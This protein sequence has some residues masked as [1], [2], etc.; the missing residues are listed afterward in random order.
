MSSLLVTGGAGFIGSNLIR[1]LLAHDSQVRVVNLDL[2]TYAGNLESLEDVT[3]CYGPAGEAR[4]W[5][6]HGDI[7]DFDTVAAVLA[8]SEQETPAPGAKARE[9]PQPDAV[10]HLAGLSNDPLGALA[11]HLTEE[12]NYEGT[13]KLA[14]LAKQAGVSR[15]IYASSQSMYG[16]SNTQQ[17]LDEDDSDKNAITAYAITKWKAELALKE[18]GDGKFAV[19]YT[20]G[21]NTGMEYHVRWYNADGSAGATFFTT[22]PGSSTGADGWVNTDSLN[23]RQSVRMDAAGNFT[24]LHR[25]DA[26][27]SD[28][29]SP[30]SGLIE[31][32]DGFLYGTAS[33]GGQPVT[34][35][36]ETFAAR[37]L[38]AGDALGRHVL[39]EEII[40][41]KRELG[42]EIPW[43]VVGVVAD[44]KVG[45]LD[46]TSAGIYVSYA[47]SPIVGVSLLARGAVGIC[48]AKLTEAEAM[49]EHGV[50]TARYLSEAARLLL[51]RPRPPEGVFCVT[52]LLACGLIDGARTLGID[53]PRELCVIGF[54]DIPQAAWPAYGLTTF[55][56]DDVGPHRV[57][58]G[59]KAGVR[60]TRWQQASEAVD[61]LQDAPGGVLPAAGSDEQFEYGLRLMVTT[62][63][64]GNSPDPSRVFSYPGSGIRYHYWPPGRLTCGYTR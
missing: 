35:V 41:G 37:Y 31:G 29:G 51:G 54:D 6:R 53:I 63:S 40:T 1:W 42:P 23:W 8:G 44:E 49:I 32:R 14:R 17:E 56:R 34:V 55:R 43:Q 26:Y 11:P 36:N 20:R 52:D 13:I 61:A 16:I 12:I 57:A 38:S 27:A 18:M 24:V 21:S 59:V 62:Q 2:L 19:V 33:I 45:S 47:Q 50:D 46:N 9:M 48:C 58:M 15:F 64:S 60:D 30:M 3:R 7:R 22:L 10:I 4:Y 25:F 39:V 5:F 28:G